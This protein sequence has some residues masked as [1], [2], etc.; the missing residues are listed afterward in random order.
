MELKHSWNEQQHKIIIAAQKQLERKSFEI[1]LDVAVAVQ[2]ALERKNIPFYK[3]WEDI[4]A[5]LAGSGS[6]SD[7]YWYIVFLQC[8]TSVWAENM[9]LQKKLRQIPTAINDFLQDLPYLPEPQHLPERLSD[10]QLMHATEIG[11]IPQI[12]MLYDMMQNK[13][14]KLKNIYH[15]LLNKRSYDQA[16]VLHERYGGLD[17]IDPEILQDHFFLKAD[18]SEKKQSFNKF[19]CLEI[20]PKAPD[21]WVRAHSYCILD[22]ILETVLECGVVPEGTVIKTP[23]ARLPLREFLLLINELKENLERFFPWK[24]VCCEMKSYMKS[25][26]ASAQIYSE[27]DKK[28]HYKTKGVHLCRIY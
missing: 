10:K 5:D 21:F 14:K 16:L 20:L 9:C 12:I 15:I 23:L 24:N 2:I 19:F 1:S 7:P 28:N 26:L 27:W 18:D 6:F 13:G 8:C 11:D 3:G 25:V 22:K 17:K 4:T